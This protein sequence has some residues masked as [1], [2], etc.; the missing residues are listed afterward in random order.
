MVV[1]V[2]AATASAHS[3]ADLVEVIARAKP[4]VVIVGTFNP[5]DSPRFTLKGTGFIVADG[6][7]VVTNAHV[8]TDGADAE[9]GGPGTRQVVQVWRG[10]RQWEMRNATVATVDRGHDLAVLRFDGPPAPTLPLAPPGGIR[11]GQ[12]IAFIGFPIGGV[13]GYSHV[14]HRGIISS[15]TAAA[16]PAPQARQL[17]D[18]AV[19]SLADGPIEIYQLDAVAYPGNSGGPVLNVDTG[20]VVG[21]ISMVL[22]KGTRESALSSPTG[23]TYAIPVRYVHEA[24]ERR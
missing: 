6:N 23:L 22:I 9:P 13:L 8:L 18:R 14:T 21:V 20:D 2:V 16:L 4:S 17:T 1:A 10:P 24:I 11:E 5:T 3:A 15:I 12:S 19:R 7:H